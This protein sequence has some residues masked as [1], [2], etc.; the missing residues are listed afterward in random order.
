MYEIRINILVRHNHILNYGN[1]ILHFF[2]QSKT[3]VVLL[4]VIIFRD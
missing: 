4:Q 3:V 1:I 2:K